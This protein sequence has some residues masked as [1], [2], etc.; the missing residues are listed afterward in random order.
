MKKNYFVII[1][2]KLDVPRKERESF[3]K[4]DAIWSE[5]AKQKIVSKH[6]TIGEATE[7]L[8][9]FECSYTNHGIRGWSMEEY[10]LVVCNVDED[11]VYFDK[12]SCMLAEEEAPSK[13]RS[14]HV[15]ERFVLDGEFKTVD[16]VNAAI[17]MQKHI[18]GDYFDDILAKM[19]WENYVEY[20]D[21]K[22][23]ILEEFWLN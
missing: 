18:S 19:S 22:T 14:V 8:K 15:A 11:G 1:Q 7:K 2:G 23:I 17:R 12:T 5:A 20:R 10:A 21:G 9:K 4:G 13:G 3:Q 6:Y 16:E